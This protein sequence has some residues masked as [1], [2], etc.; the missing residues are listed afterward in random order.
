MSGRAA[1]HVPVRAWIGAA[2]IV[3]LLLC[4][5]L[6]GWLAPHDPLEQDLMSGSLPPVWHDGG[7]KA[8]LFGTD[9]LGR[10]IFSRLIWGAR[11]AMI[12][13]FAGAGL[14]A[15]IGTLVGLWAGFHGGWVDVLAS[16]LVDIWMSFP[17]VLLS[18]VLV[19]VIG[20][21]LTSVVLAI[22]IIDWTRFC[23]VVRAETQAQVRLDYVTSARTIGLSRSRTLWRE[24]LPNLVP[25]LLTLFTLEMGIAVVVEAILSFVGL[26][27]SSDTPTWGGLIRDGRLYVN[28]TPWL[29]GL[30][31]AAVAATVLACNALGDGLR[32]AADPLLRR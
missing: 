30:P 4:A 7:D 20:T 21:G 23:R 24:V 9:T 13:A 32:E 5:L 11:P 2:V 22:A 3:A 1:L 25:L 6:A 14:A 31:I 19:A 27:V 12:V 26:S 29:L 10:D 8:F 28:Q 16:R 15:L 17:A 18:I